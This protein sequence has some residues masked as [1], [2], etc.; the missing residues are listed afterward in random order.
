MYKLCNWFTSQLTVVWYFLWAKIWGVMSTR[1]LHFV[2]SKKLWKWCKKVGSL[3][4]ILYLYLVN[5]PYYFLYIT[6]FFFINKMYNYFYNKITLF[7]LT[8][9]TTN[10][11][12]R[13][14]ITNL[15][16]VCPTEWQT[17]QDLPSVYKHEQR[18]Y[19]LHSLT[20]C[21]LN[22][23]YENKQPS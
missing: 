14:H 5:Q 13:T 21:Y 3:Y 23:L 19:I 4:V 11:S 7:T 6:M 20:L 17:L 18:L 22:S 12:N 9:N 15:G 2:L 10:I 16:R 8:E 1:Q